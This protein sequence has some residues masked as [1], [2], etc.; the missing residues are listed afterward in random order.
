MLLRA[1]LLRAGPLILLASE[2]PRRAQLL[3]QAKLP[4]VCVAAG[5]EEAVSLP[6]ARDVRAVEGFAGGRALSKLR[7]AQLHGTGLP[8]DPEREPSDLFVRSAAVLLLAV[9]TVVS[10][11]GQIFGKPGSRA[12][13]RQ[14]LS[15]LM[16][17]EHEVVSA[18][19]FQR[20]VD[21][22]AVGEPFLRM[23]RARLRVRRL[24]EE[25]LEAYLDAG[26]WRGKAGGY[27][28]QG[29]AASF[30]EILEGCFDCVVGLSIA[31]VRR[32]FE[33]ALPNPPPST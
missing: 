7:G 5:D 14:T 23:D 25:Q 12:Q 21:S 20:V 26:D 33:A 3:A 1:R 28:I 24:S 27:G 10:M 4:F 29:L 2:S 18:H 8:A 19:A 13:A 16:G 22:R 30:V 11:D 31:I 17:C 32:E 6:R 9:D 15:A